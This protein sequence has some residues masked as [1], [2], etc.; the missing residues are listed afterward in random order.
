MGRQANF[1][2]LRDAIRRGQAKIAEGLKTGQMRSDH[3]GKPSSGHVP[4]LDPAHES[5]SK[6]PTASGKVALFEGRKK[7]G[8][9]FSWPQIR[10][11]WPN[12]SA[13][14]YR[15]MVSGIAAI[16][17]VA[18]VV[19]VVFWIGKVLVGSEPSPPVAQGPS[20]LPQSP[21]GSESTPTTP[22][23][24][25]PPVTAE[26]P[27]T[28]TGTQGLSQ[29]AQTQ[30]APTPAP[31]QRTGNNA[32][33][34][35]GIATSR[36]SELIPVQEFFARHGIETEIL[37]SGNNYSR[38]ITKGRFENPNRPGTDGYEMRMKI[39]NLGKRYPVETGDTKFGTEPFQDAYG[40]LIQ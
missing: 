7:P 31:V 10:V 15:S 25:S 37:R 12:L 22:V 19:F 2:E 5:L 30:P 14:P 29:P 24:A 13:L 17:V 33:V 6:K 39:K 40:L 32:I 3:A 11:P 38:L 16:L 9:R 35:Q 1:S 21:I 20:E 23:S 26:S 18:V 28:Q 4:R 8:F 34:I 27:R 36:E